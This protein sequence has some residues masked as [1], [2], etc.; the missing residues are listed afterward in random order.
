VSRAY[1]R[2]RFARRCT[3]GNRQENAAHVWSRLAREQL[4]NQRSVAE[5]MVS[6]E[7]WF[8]LAGVGDVPHAA[9]GGCRGM[10]G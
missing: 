2:W 6:R 3:F 8:R 1:G 4:F 5:A 9:R 10:A 7:E